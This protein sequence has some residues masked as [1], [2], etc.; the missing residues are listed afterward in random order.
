MR[1][2]VKLKD[3]VRQKDRH[4]LTVILGSGGDDGAEEF[5]VDIPVEMRKDRFGGFLVIPDSAGLNVLEESKEVK[6][7]EVRTR[8]L[9]GGAG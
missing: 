1:F 2:K 6:W 7:V 5:R 9:R 4:R 8:S 3:S